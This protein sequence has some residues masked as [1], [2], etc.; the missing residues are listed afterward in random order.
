LDAAILEQL[1]S[2]YAKLESAVELE[3]DRSNHVDQKDLISMLEQVA[4]TSDKISLV[5]GAQESAVPRFRLK[6]TKVT[7]TGIPSGHEFTSLVLVIL[8]ADKKGKLPDEAILDRVR[9]L[10]GPIKLRTF[11]SLTCENCPD[12]VQALNIM[13]LTHADFSHEMIDGAYT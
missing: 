6:G 1:K 3:Y 13:A 5:A 4:S 2:V 12:V 7:F 8:H 10:K 11:I 9:R